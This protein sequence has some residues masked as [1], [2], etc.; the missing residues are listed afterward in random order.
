MKVTSYGYIVVLVITTEGIPP[1]VKRSV[2]PP[3]DTSTPLGLPFGQVTT[4]TAPA[5][6]LNTY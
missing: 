2:N 5:A 6:G 3:E 1:I 4:G